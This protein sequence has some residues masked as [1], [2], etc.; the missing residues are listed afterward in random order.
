MAHWWYSKEKLLKEGVNLLTNDGQTTLIHVACVGYFEEI[1]PL[2]KLGIDPFIKDKVD[3]NVLDYVF[4]SRGGWRKEEALE[5]VAMLMRLG[6][7]T[8]KEWRDYVIDQE[9]VTVYR[10]YLALELLCG[11]FTIDILR[12]VKPFIL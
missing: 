9:V 11:K 4:L 7:R 6:V 12:A 3:A 5:A 1:P 2:L 10:G 8:N